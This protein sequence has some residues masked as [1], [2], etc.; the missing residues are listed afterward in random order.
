MRLEKTAVTLADRYRLGD[1]LGV[2]NEDIGNLQDLFLRTLFP[3][4]IAGSLSIALIIAGGF[5]SLWFALGLALFLGFLIVI[6]PLISLK[7]TVK[8]DEELKIYRNQLFL[9]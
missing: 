9:I 8:L 6:L 5:F 1:L 3:V 2:L 4:L 7:F